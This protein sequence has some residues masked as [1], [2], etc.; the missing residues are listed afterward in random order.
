MNSPDFPILEVAEETSG[1]GWP[2]IKKRYGLAT[3]VVPDFR[4]CE[5]GVIE[6]CVEPMHEQQHVLARSSGEPFPNVLPEAL[7]SSL[8]R[9]P[10][11][12]I[13]D[14]SAIHNAKRQRHLGKLT[15][16]LRLVE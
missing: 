11:I 12:L 16:F 3:R 9:P 8:E 7:G 6:R 2:G 1:P 10:R 13:L 15:H 5:G 4:K 14:G